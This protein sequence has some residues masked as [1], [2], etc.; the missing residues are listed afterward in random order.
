MQTWRAHTGLTA[1]SVLAAQQRF[2]WLIEEVGDRVHASDCRELQATLVGGEA[3]TAQKERALVILGLMGTARAE[4]ALRWYDSEGAP[5]RVSLLRRLALRE[6]VRRRQS[7][8][9]VRADGTT[10]LAA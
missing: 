6:C 4:A 1:E 5:P 8:R 7:S 9:Q 2:D 10:H 3:R